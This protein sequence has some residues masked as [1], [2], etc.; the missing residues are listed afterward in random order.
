MGDEKKVTIFKFVQEALV[1]KF[2]EDFHKELTIAAKELKE[3]RQIEEN[4]VDDWDF[5]PGI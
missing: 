3:K 1:R 4:T 5:I 2:G